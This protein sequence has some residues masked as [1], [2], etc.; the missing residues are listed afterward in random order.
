MYR[1]ALEIGCPSGRYTGG[2]WLS[3][4]RVVRC[5]VKSRNERNPYPVLPAS[6][7]GDSQETAGVNSEEGGDDVKSSCPLCPGLQTRYNGRYRGLRSRE[8]ERIPQ[9][10]SQ[11]GLESATRLHEAGVAS[12]PGS[13]RQ[14]EYVPGPCTHRPSHHESRQHPKPVAQPVRGG[15][16]EGGVGDWGEVVTR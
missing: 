9:S 11:F 5:W 13:A 4:A 14:G 6:N 10:R 8:G 1:K 2:A 7:V 15:A 16:V 3:S 12:N